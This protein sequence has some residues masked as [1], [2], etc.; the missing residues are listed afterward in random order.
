[1]LSLSLNLAAM[2]Y[3]GNGFFCL[4]GLSGSYIG[5]EWIHRLT[6]S[7]GLRGVTVPAGMLALIVN[8]E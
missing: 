1:M 3:N 7:K 4:I 6:V 8:S 5:D 2:T